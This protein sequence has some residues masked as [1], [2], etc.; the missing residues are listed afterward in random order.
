MRQFSTALQ[1]VLDSGEI[2]YA[3][4]IKLSFNSTYYITSNSYDVV[5]GGNTYLADSGLF[6]VDSPKNSTVVDRESYTIMV[7]DLLDEMLTEFKINVVGKPVE[8]YLAFKDA[9]GNLL[10]TEGDVIKVYKGTVD[11]PSISNDFEEKIAKIE[12]TSPMSD[13]DLVRSFITSKDGMDQ[14]SDTDTSFDEVY[15]GSEITVKWG[16]V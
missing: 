3:F 13:L 16:K 6:N 1:A 14:K 10:L 4:L 9:S 8:V 7:A 12:G 15:S 2:E 5:Y 11:K